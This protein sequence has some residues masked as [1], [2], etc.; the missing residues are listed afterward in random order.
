[1]EKAIKTLDISPEIEVEDLKPIVLPDSFGENVLSVTLDGVNVLSSVS[2]KN[3]NLNKAKLP[4]TADKLGTREMILT[5]ADVNYKFTADMYTLKIS[6]KAEFDKMRDL[7]RSN[8]NV[9][10]T[11]VLDGYFVLDN[12]IEYNAEF[13]S[14]TDSGE[15]WS[16]NNKLGGAGWDDPSKYGFKGV[17]DG[18]GYNVNGITVKS[19]TSERESGGIFG[20]LNNDAVIKNVSFT[21]AGLY[22]NN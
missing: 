3:V 12:N 6:N 9:S 8:G 5:T 15:V 10:N 11:G 2:D 17:F 14:M 1:M 19:R 13:V 7:A 20:Y 21:D 18:C 4:Q 16:V 22:E